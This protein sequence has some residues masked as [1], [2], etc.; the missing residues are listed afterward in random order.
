[1]MT[2]KSAGQALTGCTSSGY[3]LDLLVQAKDP[4]GTFV[5]CELVF[6]RDML[7]SLKGSN[8]PLGLFLLIFDD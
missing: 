7:T 1:M 6:S 8:F 5:F 4:G 3:I 2:A